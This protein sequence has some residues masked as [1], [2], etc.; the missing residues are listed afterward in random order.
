MG[1]ERG[2]LPAPE[3]GQALGFRH[4]GKQ[5]GVEEFIPEPPVER[6][7]KDVYPW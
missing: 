4:R 1:P 5:F 2:L 7:C 3:I 6:L